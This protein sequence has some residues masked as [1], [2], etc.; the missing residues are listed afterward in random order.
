VVSVLA[1]DNVYNIDCIDL[2]YQVRMNSHPCEQSSVILMWQ[3]REEPEFGGFP[4]AA[5]Q[6]ISPTI[7]TEAGLL[8]LRAG[9]PSAANLGDTKKKQP[10]KRRK[11]GS[12]PAELQVWPST[13]FPYVGKFVTG[14]GTFVGLARAGHTG[15]AYC[16]AYSA[17]RSSS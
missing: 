9:D 6:P 2:Q 11:V 7:K 13:P 3:M 12:I 4:A 1:F 16:V 8:S 14:F 10:H 5:P 15:F 17:R